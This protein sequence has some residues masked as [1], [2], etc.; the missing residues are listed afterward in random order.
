MNATAP[1]DKGEE[2]NT[3]E[4]MEKVILFN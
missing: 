2:K 1:N 3:N 4:L